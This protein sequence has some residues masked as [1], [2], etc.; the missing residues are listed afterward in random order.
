MSE[1]DG[2]EPGAWFAAFLPRERSCWWD[3]L[4]PRDFRHVHCFGFAAAAGVWLH[5]SVGRGRTELAAL[6]PEAFDLYIIG[7]R[8]EGARILRYE[9]AGR[10]GRRLRVGFWCTPAAAHLMGAR[11]S[12]LRPVG[13]YRDLLRQGAKPAFEGLP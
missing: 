6:R 2:L 3:W 12:A 11:S 9:P 1:V 4:S 10:P 8:N 7:L 13:L 5:Y